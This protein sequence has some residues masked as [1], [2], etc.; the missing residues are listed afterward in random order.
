[1]FMRQRMVSTWCANFWIS[2]TAKLPPDHERNDPRQ[3]TLV[4]KH[5][6]IKHQ[7]SVIRERGWN[8]SRLVKSRKLS[9]HLF[10]SSLNPPFDIADRFK[11]LNKLSCITRPESTP[12]VSHLL[13]NGIEQTTVAL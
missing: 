4:R 5:L 2:A 9:G 10:F 1:M 8:T 3:V 12:N 13:G 7:P 6:Q 11:I